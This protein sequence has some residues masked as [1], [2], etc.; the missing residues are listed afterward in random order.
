M[1]C[2]AK[3][4]AEA[5]CIKAFL[6]LSLIID[7]RSLLLVVGLLSIADPS[8]PLSLIGTILV[9]LCLLVWDWRVSRAEPMLS[10]WH[11]RLFFLSPTIYLSLLSMGWMC[12]VGLFRLIDVLTPGL[13]QLTPVNN[14]NN[15]P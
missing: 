15:I 9:T 3:P 5:G 11:N 2:L 4:E 7:T 14:N 8:C 13:A 6:S 12:W 10:C 1:A